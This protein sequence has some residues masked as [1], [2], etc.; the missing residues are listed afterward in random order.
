MFETT[1]LND[2]RRVLAK[3]Y[4]GDVC[5]K[6]FAN[7]TQARKA[8]EKTRA[9]VPEGTLVKITGYQPFYVTL[10]DWT[11][12]FEEC[13][14]EF[15]NEIVELAAVHGKTVQQVYLWWREYAD[16][17]SGEGGQSALMFDFTR[18]YAT[19]LGPA[20]GLRIRELQVDAKERGDSE[21]WRRLEEI[22]RQKGPA[23]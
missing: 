14:E 20:N 1:M 3:K 13:C 15:R 21:A 17:V 5:A 6:T 11:D 23:S 22:A 4:K 19:K 8:A 18:W 12:L 7:L 10:V 16:S 9:E 2:G